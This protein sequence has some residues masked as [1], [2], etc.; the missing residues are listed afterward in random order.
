M[1]KLAW[2]CLAAALKAKAGSGIVYTCDSS[3][4]AVAPAAC[5]TLNTTIAGLYA[6]AFTNANAN[7]Y[8]KLGNAQ[9]GRSLSSYSVFSYGE[10]RAAL[11]GAA[12]SAS[13]Q[14][15]LAM[16]VP[17]VSPFS[18]SM[19]EVNN[20]L[21]RALG[22]GTPS[23]GVNPNGGSCNFN[24][25]AQ[26]YDGMIVLSAS[27]Q[28]YFR[29]GPISGQQY[30]FFSVVEHE[31]DE[32]LGTPS[33]GFDDCGID[34]APAD[35]FRYHSNGTRADKPGSNNVTCSAPDASNACF[36]IDGVNMLI[37]FNNVNNGDDAGDWLTNCQS[38]LVQDAERCAG[39]AGVD[40]TESAEI[41]LLDVVGYTTRPYV[42]KGSYVCTNT[43]APAISF[44]DSA[45]AYGG[46]SYFAP[47]SWLEIKGTNLADANDPRLP[48]NGG[49]GQWTE[50]D[51]QGPNAPTSLDGVSVTINGKP[52]YVWYI[53]TGQLNVQAP[54]ETATG[55][56]A[57]TVTNCQGESAAYPFAERGLA[58]GLLAP[59]TYFS[60]GKQYLVATFVSDG[61][62][63]LDTSVG[64]GFG[65][66]SRPAK[67]G[68]VII[69]YGVGFGGVTPA[70]L[71]GVIA[72]QTNMLTAAVSISFNST[73]A[74]VSVQGLAGNFV[75]LYEFYITVPQGL[76][77]GD[78]KINVTQNGKPLPQGAM[79]LTV[80]N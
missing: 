71:P 14:T 74:A 58:A 13:D 2:V 9:L 61:A 59:S 36:S 57:I 48:S 60:G 20:A 78:Y 21:Q 4:T 41:L 75:G 65:L 26:C 27:Q 8:V 1:K 38:Q 80:Q 34:Y 49:T 69:G 33:C 6:A 35:L 24:V 19:L 73:P 70:I 12:S 76:A 62:Y 11:A 63:V 10:Y 51:F 31:T 28:L 67:P 68:D 77:N 50:A 16:S 32:I 18:N 15:A 42:Q 22:L 47:G 5:D 45:S 3:L 52:A 23:F 53:S 29:S 37:Q 54:E 64:A 43:V 55:D 25:S 66:K 17:P 39:M 46:Y 72:G 44:V 40:I 79:Y 30:D 56:V 7:I